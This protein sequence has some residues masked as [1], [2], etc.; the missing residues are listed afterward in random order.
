[1]TRDRRG[2]GQV[3]RSG[4]RATDRAARSE[5]VGEHCGPKLGRSPWDKGGVRAASGRGG[6]CVRRVVSP[7][8]RGT[9]RSERVAHDE[10]GHARR[11][12]LRRPDDLETGRVEL[13][14]RI[15]HCGRVVE[16]GRRQR[17]RLP[18][19]RGPN[20]A[21]TTRCG[22]S[23]VPGAPEVVSRPACDM[24]TRPCGKLERGSDL[25]K[26]GPPKVVAPRACVP[27]RSR[28]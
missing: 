12:R 22:A 20:C 15:G 17:V 14:L 5:A 19:G 3:H 6:W 4:V 2:D 10:S 18:T 11:H 9:P 1:M 13:R 26:R 27:P 7:A 23:S 16:T 25:R 28:A 21:S 24:P 8:R